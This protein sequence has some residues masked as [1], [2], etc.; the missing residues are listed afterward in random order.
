[1]KQMTDTAGT[2]PLPPKERLQQRLLDQV[3]IQQIFKVSRGTVYN[4]SRKGLL[5]FT[6][7]GGRKY[8][9]VDDLEAVIERNKSSYEVKGRKKEKL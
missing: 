4:W 6:Q 7:F 5:P 9:D 2:N 8:F 3:E 1:M